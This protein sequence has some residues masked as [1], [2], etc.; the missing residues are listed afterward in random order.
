[1]DITLIISYRNRIKELCNCLTTA[2]TTS[3][4]DKVILIDAAS[5]KETN[6]ELQEFRLKWSK[7]SIRIVE[8]FYR[9]SLSEAWNLGVMLSDTRYVVFASS[10]VNFLK[11]GWKEVFEE[12]FNK[13]QQYV[14]I[15]N[16]AVF[17]L[18]K[19]LIT[20]IGWF[21][22]GFGIGPHFDCDY[23]IR[24]SEAGVLP[25]FVGDAGLYE[26]GDDL[27]ISEKRATSEVED[28][29]PMNTIENE[30]YFKSKWSS[31]WPGWVGHYN[32]A[33]GFP[34]PPTSIHGLTRLKAEIDPHPFYTQKFRELY[35]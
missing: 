20:K 25:S 9:S 8:S 32:P 12:S 21:D 13:S 18:D 7:K 31:S 11:S 24:A 4:I 19:K 10:D 5:N 27:I 29:L 15:Y 26:H 28:R 3:N 34:H 17:G 35:P 33:I 2:F 30:Q 16:H 1:M 22:E 23:M 14:L 6:T